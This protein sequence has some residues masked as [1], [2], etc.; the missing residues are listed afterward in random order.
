MTRQLISKY[1]DQIWLQRLIISPHFNK[2]GTLGEAG[3]SS[4]THPLPPL[5]FMVC[6]RSRGAKGRTV[7][8]WCH[9]ASPAAA[10]YCKCSVWVKSGVSWDIWVMISKQ[11]EVRVL[12]TERHYIGCAKIK[13]NAHRQQTWKRFTC[14]EFVKSNACFIGN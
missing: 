8:Y 7:L 11:V 2:I 6:S 14:K 10:P 3:F 13:T 5:L 9:G 1:K 12:I 4:L